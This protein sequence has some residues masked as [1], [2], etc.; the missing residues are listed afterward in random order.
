M[1]EL[2]L[3]QIPEAIYFSLFLIF[4]KELK[5]K[6]ILFVIVMILEYVLSLNIQIFST[7]SHIIYTILVFITLKV[8]Y[9]EKAQI[10]DV[11]TFGI[12]SVI[13]MVIS[14]VSY[15]LFLQNDVLAVIINRILTIITPILLR[16]KLSV[17]EDTYK[18]FWNKRNNNGKIIKSTTFRSVSLIVFNTMFYIINLG[19]I[20]ALLITW[21]RGE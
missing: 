3:G 14:V 19:M 8:L 20:Y 15:F 1:S 18:K 4:T 16:N 21:K 13:L 12:S 11:F 6:R 5:T 10:T 9:K 2:L 7:W 17:I